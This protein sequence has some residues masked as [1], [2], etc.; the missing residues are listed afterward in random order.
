M[1]TIGRIVS[2]VYQPAH[3]SPPAEFRNQSFSGHFLKGPKNQAVEQVDEPARVSGG[4]QSKIRIRT[5][6]FS[7]YFS[8]FSRF[9]SFAAS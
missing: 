3:P 2:R 7:R 6:A 8:Y 9:V 4:L 5:S 1:T